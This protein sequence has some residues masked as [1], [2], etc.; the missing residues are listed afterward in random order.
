[1][2]QARG[3]WASAWL[4]L[5]RD[6]WSMVAL[7]ALAVV[8]LLS[9]F[10]GAVATRA[11]G[12]DGQ[13]PFPYATRGETLRP[14]GPWTRVP[15]TDQVIVD[16]Y[17]NVLPPKH[18]KRTLFVFG[19]D[20]P[21][22]RDELIRLL[23]GGRTS[24]EVG[25]GAVLFALLVAIPVGCAA[26][27]YRGAVDAVVSRFTETI[28]AFPLLL[29]LVFTTAKLGPT[30]SQ[31]NYSWLLPKGVFTDAV[32]I[33]LFTSFYPTRLIRAQLLTLRNAEFVD[34]AHMIGASDWRILRRHLLPHLV[35]TLLVWGA[36][37]V[38]TN[39]LLEVSLSFIGVGVEPSVPTWGSMLATIWGT[40]YSPKLQNPVWWQ[41]ILPTT[42]ILIT[43]VSLNQLS[44][45]IR[46]AIEPW[47]RR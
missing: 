34:S 12:H 47:S 2:V 23:D 35:P 46:R 31:V 42:G 20:G 9:L 44:E 8:I 24:L 40:I 5:R 33:G 26:G 41:T 36:I 19:S 22:G 10:G 32:L 39:I 7:A 13:R 18:A 1:M 3:P 16:E 27:Y 38:A 30:L 17:G 4:R 15:A 6:R 28:M 45:G 29:F 11:L 14:V 25:I 37:A 43:V 21:L